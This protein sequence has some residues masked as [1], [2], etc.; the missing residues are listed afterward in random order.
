MFDAHIHYAATQGEE[1]MD[2]ALARYGLDACTLQCI[3][4]RGWYSTVPDALAYKAKHPKRV[5]VNG[6]LE[7]SAWVLLEGR[8][9]ALGEALVLQARALR[10]AGCDGI[11]LLEGKP[12]I[13][14][15]FPIPD[16]DT[17]AWEPFWAWAEAER[18]PVTMHLND[19]EE[20]WDAAKINPYAKKEGWF[21]GP[22]TV[23]NEEQYRQMEVV[24]ARHP[25]LRLQLAHLY[26]LSAQLPRLT[27]LLRAYPEVRVDLTPGIE[28]YTN[29]AA[30]LPGARALFAEFGTRILYGTD[31]GS[32]SCIAQP[33][34]ALDAE[35]SDARVRVIRTFLESR[36]PYTLVP[37]GKY[38]FRIDPTP[39]EGLA[40]ESAAL[41]DVYDGNAR[42]LYGERPCPVNAAV[43]EALTAGYRRGLA[44]VQLRG[45]L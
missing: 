33:P 21:Y 6:G 18:C 43:A 17:A 29:L 9:D 3:P 41:M 27:A 5:Y 42:A 31:I 25:R 32:R 19:P 10:R 23:N 45:K 16:F 4:Q 28:L 13:R 7:R 22:D 39:M 34:C 26:F 14:R 30:N 11:K 24:L 20:F 35:E 15:S 44:E 12:D 8:P 38:L 2:A 36:G 37:D 40:L 1:R